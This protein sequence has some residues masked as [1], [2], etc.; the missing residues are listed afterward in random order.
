MIDLIMTGFNET[1]DKTYETLDRN[2][3]RLRTGRASPALVD[4]IKVN[5]YGVPTPLKQVASISTPEPRLIVIQPWDQKLC[6][7]IEKEIQKSNLGVTPQ[8]D[9]KLI[10]LNIPTLTD[11]RRKDLVKTI[12]K[13]GEEAKIAMRNQRR[14]AN[15]DLEELEKGKEISEDEL[16]KAQESVKDLLDKTI[17]E[18]DNRIDKKTK[19]IQEV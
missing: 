10:R 9:G 5:Y 3:A 17:E 13:I 8:N 14:T 12:N 18:I 11:E 16:H 1:R 4:G 19:E 2:L 7:D 6:S 15:K